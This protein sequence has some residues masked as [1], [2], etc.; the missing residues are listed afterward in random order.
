[1]SI[2]IVASC[3]ATYGTIQIMRACDGFIKEALERRSSFSGGARSA[4][5]VKR[6]GF[7]SRW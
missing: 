2:I 7:E 5:G 3:I 1:M 4:C 6:P